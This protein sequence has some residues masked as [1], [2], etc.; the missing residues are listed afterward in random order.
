MESI[1]RGPATRI[2]WLLAVPLAM[3]CGC[4]GESTP[5]GTGDEPATPDVEEITDEAPVDLPPPATLQ[6]AA[7]RV[8]GPHDGLVAMDPATGEIKA[9]VHPDVVVRGL[10]PPGSTF[11]L[12]VAHALLDGGLVGPHDEVECAGSISRGG[13][14]YRCSMRDGHGRRDVVRALADSCNVFFYTQ[15]E[16]LGVPAIRQA[17]DDF[18]LLEPTGFDPDEPAGEFP[19]DLS[20]DRVFLLGAGNLTS[21]RVTPLRMLVAFSALM[22]DGQCRQPWQGER[23]S[24]EVTATLPALFEYQALL[25][26]GLEGAV[27]SGTAAA[28]AVP[29]EQVLGK[30]GTIRNPDEPTRTINWFLGY[31]VDRR[32]TVCVVMTHATGVE[33]AAEAFGTIFESWR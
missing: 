29:G 19:A 1:S 15:G 27:E 14:V 33:P 13:T 18:E 23:P 25:V 22:G 12:I 26:D 11:K 2:A 5:A 4:C 28:A 20:P 16:R 7:E 8:L 21:L 17:V 9:L 30:T 6:Q 24:G 32:L 3:V 31:L 10:Y